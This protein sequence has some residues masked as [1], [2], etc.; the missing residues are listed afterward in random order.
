MPASAL[1]VLSAS[2]GSPQQPHG[3]ITAEWAQPLLCAG[4]PPAAMHAQ[5]AHPHIHLLLTVAVN[6]IFWV[7]SAFSEQEH[8]VTV[9]DDTSC[10]TLYLCSTLCVLRWGPDRSPPRTL[11]SSLEVQVSMSVKGHKCSGV[12]LACRFLPRGNQTWQE[13]WGVITIS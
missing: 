13:T 1:S 6:H 5:L 4:R 10:F 3:V 9:K 8:S 12:I 11:S 2:Q 7:S